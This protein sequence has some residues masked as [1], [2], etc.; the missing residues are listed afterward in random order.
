MTIGQLAQES[1]LPASTIRY[2][3]GIGVLPQPLRVNGQRRY[4]EGAVHR[5]SVI[6]LARACGFRLDE[7]RDLFQGFRP[8]VPAS[9]RWQK[10]ALAKRGELEEQMAKLRAMRRVV[11]RV[12]ECSCAELAECGRIAASVMEASTR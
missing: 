9:R 12:L 2:Y 1:G 6:R 5:L 4:G 8:G 7:M 3:E 10:L 11:D